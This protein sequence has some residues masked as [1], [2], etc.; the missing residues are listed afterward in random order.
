MNQAHSVPIAME[1]AAS[2]ISAMRA[3]SAWAAPST[4]T[5]CDRAR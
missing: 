2:E 4:T 3:R 5:A 1:M